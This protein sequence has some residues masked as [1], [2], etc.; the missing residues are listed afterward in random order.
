MALPSPL[1][2]AALIRDVDCWLI[3]TSVSLG[4]IMGRYWTIYS[5]SI[6]SRKTSMA[7]NAFYDTFM[8]RSPMYFIMAGMMT[9][10]NSKMSGIRCSA[11]KH[12]ALI[13]APLTYGASC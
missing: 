10:W 5:C 9:E 3:R 1:I 6:P 11:K 8:L 4:T 12:R 7:I 13:A 2:E